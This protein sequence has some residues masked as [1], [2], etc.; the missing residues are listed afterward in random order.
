MRRKTGCTYPGPSKMQH[1]QGMRT[2]DEVKQLV[3]WLRFLGGP[4]ASLARYA[5]QYVQLPTL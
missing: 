3:G 2:T 1:E 4:A 5:A